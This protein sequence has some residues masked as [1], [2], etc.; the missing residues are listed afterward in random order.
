[1][2][3]RRGSSVYTSWLLAGG[4]IGVGLYIGTFQKPWASAIAPL[5][6]LYLDLL[7]MCILPFLLAVVTVSLG[8]LLRSSHLAGQ[9]GRIVTVFVVGML[10]ASIFGTLAGV[11]WGP[12]RHLPPASLAA[13]G[14]MVQQAEQSGEIRVALSGEVVRPEQPSLLR[15]VVDAVPQN[16]FKALSDGAVIKVL[17]FALIFGVALALVPNRNGVVMTRALEAVYGAFQKIIHWINYLLPLALCAMI[18]DHTARI[19]PQP[20][21]AMATFVLG[22]AIM[23]AV[24]LVAC[25]LIV[26]WRSGKSYWAALMALK[27]PLLLAVATRSSLNCIPASIEALQLNLRFERKSTELVVPL[28]MTLCR[29]GPLLYYAFATVFAA[30][31]YGVPLNL[32]NIVLVIV[33]VWLAGVASIGTTGVLGLT[34]MSMPFGALGLPMEAPLALFIAIDPLLDAMRTACIV[35]GNC[36]AT[37]LI[38]RLDQEP[39]HDDLAES[40]ALAPG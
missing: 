27:E 17:I 4:F 20:F 37:V 16:I 39:A 11:A 22:F 38:G 25:S 18:A 32:H 23:A 24:W 28:A 33:T 29:Y 1:M 9:L 8:R 14:S 3:V 12:G 26:Y 21:R 5:G 31:L 10:A 35:Y 19:G 7:R 13:L 2:L 34:M 36:A 30:Q 15:T 6:D 40:E